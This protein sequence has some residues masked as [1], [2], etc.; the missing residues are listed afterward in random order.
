MKLVFMGSAGFAVPSLKAL[1]ATGHEIVLVVCQPDRPKGRGQHLQAPPLKVAAEAAG[2]S[3]FQPEK[4]KAPEAV[5]KI[6]EAGADLLIVVAYGQIL[7]KA[8]LEAPRLM[9]LNVHASLLPKFR[10]AAPIEWA[11][12][13]G[14]TE[15]G[16]CV[17]KMVE[18]LDAG[19]V[20]S[21]AKLAIGPQE[22]A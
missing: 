19:D 14:E 7:P 15:T 3:V 6:Q 13:A 22:G 11:V 5:Q 16:V 9:P 10:G 1:L 18:R 12:A 4:V 2:L 8:V 21:V 20:L 17:Q